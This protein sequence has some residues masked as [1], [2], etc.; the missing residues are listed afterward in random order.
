MISTQ[1]FDSGMALLTSHF[2]RTLSDT[3]LGIWKEYLDTELDDAD[4]KSAI[5]HAILHHQFF[6][7]AGQLVE[8][9][10]STKEVRAIQEWQI[11]LQASA[12]PQDNGIAYISDRA[13][14]ALQAIG[15]LTK[16][17]LAEEWQR[18]RMEKNF[19][20]VYCQLS[21]KDSKMLPQ[22]SGDAVTSST[23]PDQQSAPM[24]EDI[25]AQIEALKGKMSMNGKKK[26]G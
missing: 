5:K 20:T 12:K 4:F 8:A 9:I 25:R 17:G 24:P 16:V 6:P 11:I 18:Q 7:T 26:K 15:G 19:I 10:K 2:N 21:N 1:V 3:V 14:I 13:R 22:S 23:T